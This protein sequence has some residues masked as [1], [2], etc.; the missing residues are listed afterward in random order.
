[1]N[2]NADLAELKIRFEKQT[3]ELQDLRQVSSLKAIGLK[4]LFS[5]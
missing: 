4:Q 2:T 1:M 5:K 3:A